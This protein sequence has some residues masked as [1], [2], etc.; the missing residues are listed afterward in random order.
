MNEKYIQALIL[1]TIIGFAII[2]DDFIAPK[3]NHKMMQK[4]LMVKDIKKLPHWKEDSGKKIKL[5]E[6][7]GHEVLVFKSD[8]K[9]EEK[10]ELKQ[11]IKI[12]IDT[13]D[14]G[15]KETKKE[16][17][18]KVN[19]DDI[20]D[21]NVESILKEI[22]NQLSDKEL[23]KVKSKLEVAKSELES[24]ITDFT[25]EVDDVDIDIELEVDS[26]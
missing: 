24:V 21:V 11:I 23:D 3:Q 20:T 7:E 14:G 18:I 26:D 5:H 15:D 9:T 17:K 22:Q 13:K 8:D 16:I 6:T 25:N 4:H 12:K 10:N 19:T 1:G 2:I